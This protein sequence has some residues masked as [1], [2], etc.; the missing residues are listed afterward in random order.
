MSYIGV[1]THLYIV[2]DKEGH[3]K[4]CPFQFD[5]REST[6][7]SSQPV[8]TG[9]EIVE[10][11]NEKEIKPKPTEKKEKKSQMTTNPVQQ[12]KLTAQVRISLSV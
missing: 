4:T 1:Y 5:S 2:R 12:E 3:I 6:K 7:K 10:R 8:A 9:K 11:K